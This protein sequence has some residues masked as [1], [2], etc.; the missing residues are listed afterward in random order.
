[1]ISDAGLELGS[2][3]AMRMIRSWNGSSQ[4]DHLRIGN[5]VNLFTII[6]TKIRMAARGTCP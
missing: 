1:M 3:M 5:K 2:L 6:D 4:V